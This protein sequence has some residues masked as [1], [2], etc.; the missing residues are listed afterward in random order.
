[1]K[2][3]FVEDLKE[4]NVNSTELIIDDTNNYIKIIIDIIKKI[5]KKYKTL[6]PGDNNSEEN[7][8]NYRQTLAEITSTGKMTFAEPSDEEKKQMKKYILS[9][10]MV[11]KTLEQVIEEEIKK[12]EVNPKLTEKALEMSKIALRESDYSNEDIELI[13]DGVLN[14]LSAIK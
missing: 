3:F 8:S 4:E 2:K 12:R 9:V 1:M 5:K 14:T 6:S 11:N 10:S 7:I 13:I